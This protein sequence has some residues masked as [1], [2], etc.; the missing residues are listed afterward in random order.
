MIFPELVNL[1]RDCRLLHTIFEGYLIG[2]SALNEDRDD[3]LCLIHAIN[4]ANGSSLSDRYFRYY[5]LHYKYTN[6]SN[7]RV[8]FAISESY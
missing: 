8:T 3:D 2:F 1:G 7:R 4:A 5:G 6:H